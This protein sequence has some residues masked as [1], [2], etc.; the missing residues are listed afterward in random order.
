MS[1]THVFVQRLT[2]EPAL[3]SHRLEFYVDGM[4]HKIL[5]FIQFVRLPPVSHIMEEIGS[6]SVVRDGME[7]LPHPFVCNCFT[8]F[9]LLYTYQLY[10]Y[11][12]GQ[13]D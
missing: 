7:N 11:I 5:Q 13:S 12:N 8:L 4:R 3:S 6:S 1:H 2:G 10:S 9:D